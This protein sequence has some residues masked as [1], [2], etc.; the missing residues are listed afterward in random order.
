[1]S[2]P[3]PTDPNAALSV[4]QLV[5][6]CQQERSA[7]Y[8][9]GAGQSPACVALF[10]RAFAGDE[11]AWSAVYTLFDPQVRAWIGRQPLL[12]P[13]DAV[14]DSWRSFARS[15]PQR[16][17][18]VAGD[19]LSLVLAYLRTCVKSAVLM[20]IRAMRAQRRQPIGHVPASPDAAP[21]SSQPGGSPREP[22]ATAAHQGPLSLDSLAGVAAEHNIADDV[23]Q[24]TLHSHVL[25]RA[26]ALVETEQERLILHCR[27]KLWMMPREILALY[28][29]EFKDIDEIRTIVQ[30]ITRRLSHDPTIRALLER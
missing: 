1:M 30:R 4:D 5:A 14:Q 28:P 27:L 18:L 9:T 23:E 7:F 12:D 22:P 20:L 16:P 15:A 11:A 29:D 13:E 17:G 2:H 8:T 26:N 25:S 3:S 19:D 24:R 6:R 10:R 21:E